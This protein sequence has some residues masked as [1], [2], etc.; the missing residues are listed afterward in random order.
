MEIFERN[1]SGIVFHF[2]SVCIDIKSILNGIGTVF[3]MRD[4]ALGPS[5]G[6]A[7]AAFL[8]NDDK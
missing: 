8:S 3:D 6:A 1:C 4:Q 5:A 2:S 7:I